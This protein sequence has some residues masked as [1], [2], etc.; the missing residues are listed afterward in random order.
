MARPPTP[1]GDTIFVT[2][3]T[4][5]KLQAGATLPIAASPWGHDARRAQ[6]DSLVAVVGKARVAWCALMPLHRLVTAFPLV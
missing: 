6:R 3:D 4:E 5:L 2:P 1:N